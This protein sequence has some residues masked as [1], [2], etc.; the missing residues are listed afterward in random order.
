MKMRN[1]RPSSVTESRDNMSSSALKHKKELR[2]ELS[3]R[4][5]LLLTR[6]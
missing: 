3:G 4:V 2:F 1:L 5:L 6:T